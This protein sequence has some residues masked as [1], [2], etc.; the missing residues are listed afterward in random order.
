MNSIFSHV[1]VKKL[2]QLPI[3]FPTDYSK[4]LYITLTGSNTGQDTTAPVITG[5]PLN[6]IS[7]T[8]PAG[9][10]SATASWT[11]P[12]A[13]DDS[14]VAPTRSRSHAP[15]SSFPVGT[16][17]VTYRFTDRSGNSEI[18]QFQVVVVGKWYSNLE[19]QKWCEY[20]F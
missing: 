20:S 6:A 19:S 4:M 13:T 2:P 9:S 1:W 3:I 18:C 5:C 12:T 15:G 10:N 8:T 16:T 17:L 14:G 7:V 11:E